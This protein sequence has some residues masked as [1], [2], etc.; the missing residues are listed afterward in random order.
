MEPS[1]KDR[2]SRRSEIVQIVCAILDHLRWRRK[3]LGPWAQASLKNWHSV[4]RS[5]RR[6]P[7][8]PVSGLQTGY[9]PQDRSQWDPP[10][11]AST[12]TKGGGWSFESLTP[13]SEAATHSRWA[14]KRPELTIDGKRR[15]VTHGRTSWIWFRQPSSSM[16]RY[17]EGLV[18]PS[19]RR[20]QMCTK[21]RTSRQPTRSPPCIRNFCRVAEIGRHRIR[22]C[23]FHRV[24][25]EVLSKMPCFR[26]FF[27]YHF[28]KI[29]P[30][31]YT[32]LVHR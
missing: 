23:D 25:M 19:P 13:P 31:W 4:F 15:E 22:T 10:Y 5:S 28:P 24:R 1:F 26:A 20:S 6:R 8:K 14:P 21:L 32:S 27:V 18:P 9:A 3:R 17:R 30:I 11:F 16:K 29:A 7:R 12:V 2:R